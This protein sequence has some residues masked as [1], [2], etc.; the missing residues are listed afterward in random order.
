MSK[1]MLQIY[2]IYQCFMFTLNA[3]TYAQFRVSFGGG[4]FDRTIHIPL[5]NS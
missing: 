5:G 2:I 4:G 3:Y 1:L